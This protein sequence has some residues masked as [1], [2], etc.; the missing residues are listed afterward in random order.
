M[1]GHDQIGGQKENWSG[2]CHDIHNRDGRSMV[3]LLCFLESRNYFLKLI[4]AFS[5]SLASRACL[6]AIPVVSDR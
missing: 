4:A 6:K 5:N 1:E 3:H 2:L